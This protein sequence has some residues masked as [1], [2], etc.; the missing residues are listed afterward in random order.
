[1]FNAQTINCMQYS[2]ELVVLNSMIKLG[3]N[4]AN[5]INSHTEHLVQERK[6]NR[7]ITLD[8]KN[9]KKVEL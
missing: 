3:R 4:H 7:I 5:E 1:M 6:A 8:G 2:Y 9:S